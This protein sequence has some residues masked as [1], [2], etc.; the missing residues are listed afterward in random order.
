MVDRKKKSEMH[1]ISSKRPEV[2]RGHWQDA[3]ATHAPSPQKRDRLWE[4]KKFNLTLTVPLRQKGLSFTWMLA[5]N[6]W[7][8]WL[9][10][11][12]PCLLLGNR[13]TETSIIKSTNLDLSTT[14]DDFYI[15]TPCLGDATIS[16]S[17]RKNFPRPQNGCWTQK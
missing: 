15:L 4:K 10:G 3:G 8:I 5:V 14:E 12:R 13:H 1:K 2:L 16:I 7:L 11:L 17:F 6:T 9:S